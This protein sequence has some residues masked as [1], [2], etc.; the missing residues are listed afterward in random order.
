MGA[1]DDV[2]GF[3]EIG[4]GGEERGCEHDDHAENPGDEGPREVIGVGRED[5]K[6]EKIEL[7]QG[8]KGEASDDG[9]HRGGGVGSAPEKPTVKMTANGGAI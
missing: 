6:F 3:C 8:G 1:P 7:E 5:G 4:R 2:G 9:G